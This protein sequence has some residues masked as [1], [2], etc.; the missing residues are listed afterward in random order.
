MQQEYMHDVLCGLKVLIDRDWE[1]KDGYC[2]DC[3]KMRRVAWQ[4]QRVKLW[5]NLNLW[6]EL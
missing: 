6:L 2:G 3:A 5:E 1:G 4:K